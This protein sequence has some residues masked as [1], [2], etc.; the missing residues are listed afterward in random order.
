MANNPEFHLESLLRHLVQGGVDFVVIGGVAVVLQSTPRFTGDLDIS[1]AL[2][3]EN[4]DRLG[5]VLTKD[6]SR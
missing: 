2:D 6:L 1:Y 5:D 3:H 4:L